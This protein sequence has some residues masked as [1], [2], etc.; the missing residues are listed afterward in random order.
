MLHTLDISIKKLTGLVMDG[1]RSMSVRNSDV[2]SLTI[3]NVNNT[4]DCNLIIYH[5]LIHQEDL[6]EESLKM[7]NIVTVSK[8]VNF[9][10]SEGM[11]HHQFKDFLSDMESEY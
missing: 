8:L 6:C 7:T 5:C 10:R 2:S 3:N 1:A 11:N 4:T 9:V